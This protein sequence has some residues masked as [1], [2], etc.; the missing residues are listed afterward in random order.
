MS[1]KPKH[2]SQD[3]DS[4]PIASAYWVLPGSLLAGGY[5]A[6]APESAARRDLGRFLDRGVTFFLDL[7]EQDEGWPYEKLLRQEAAA[8]G[9]QA[10]H[11]RLPVRDLGT[12]SPELVA[13]AL[14]A[15]DAA[16]EAGHGVYVHC[17]GGIGRTGAIIGCYLVRNGMD[18]EQ[19]LE[20]IAGLRE[21]TTYEWIESPE[22]PGQVARVLGWPKGG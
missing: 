19:A 20:T 1:A 10:A 15:I 5:P 18:G 7:T 2:S 6:E 8:R 12:P 9:L 11:L 14:D 17:M 21:G 4:P 22:M 13:R 3:P 16:M